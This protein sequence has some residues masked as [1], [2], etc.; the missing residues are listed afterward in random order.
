[1]GSEESILVSNQRIVIAEAKEADVEA[2]ASFFWAAWKEAGPEAP[3][4]VGAS[5]EVLQEIT[6]QD[7]MLERIGSTD[8]RMFLA[9]EG[10]RV[11]G[12]AANRRIDDDTVELAGIIILQSLLGRG[13]G[14]RLLEAAVYGARRD[15]YAEM[16]VRTEVKNERAIAFYRARGF[17]LGQSVVEEIEGVSVKILELVR[18]L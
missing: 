8:G 5:E 17:A 13:I 4:W 7:H 6:A 15:G 12:F 3:G 14:S 11:V 9:R 10:D 18:D 16:S 2:I 1:M